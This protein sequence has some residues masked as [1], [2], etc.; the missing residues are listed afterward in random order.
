MIPKK[1]WTFWL[2]DKPTPPD[3]EKW[4]ESQKIPGYEHHLITLD[5][6]DRSWRYVD[7]AINAKR[8]CKAC[9][10]LRMQYL[11][12]F[13]GIHL[14]ADVEVLAG[15]NFDDLLDCKMFIGQEA[16]GI[17]NSATMGSEPNHEFM[18]QFTNL[19][20]SNF[21][22][23]GTW[24]W[25]PGLKFLNDLYQSQNPSHPW[26]DIRIIPSDFFFPYEWKIK[27][28][29]VTKNTRTFHHFLGTWVNG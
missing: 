2:S 15:K 13:G 3:I 8:W 1:I 7:E 4:V 17:L 27:K 12:N 14:D 25:E 22:G 16:E 6:V 11:F 24:V 21:R 10:F 26:W 9:D 18:Y 29:N 23:D 19:A 20:N 5:N 28:I